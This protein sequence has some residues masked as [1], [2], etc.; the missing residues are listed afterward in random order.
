LQSKE[1]GILHNKETEFQI[2]KNVSSKFELI[3]NVGLKD[4]AFFIPSVLIDVSVTL[5]VHLS[6]PTQYIIPGKIV[7]CA[8]ALFIPFALV[9]IRPIRENIPG[10]KQLLWRYQ[11]NKRQKIFKFRKKVDEFVFP[12]K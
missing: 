3:E 12:K 8:V 6:L 2:P 5:F 4:M 9:Y 1:E 7:F 10:W 11:F